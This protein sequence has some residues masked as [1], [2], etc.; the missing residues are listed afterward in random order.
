MKCLVKIAP[1][2][3]SLFV[4]INPAKAEDVFS[5]MMAGGFTELENWEVTLGG[6]VA[7]APKFEGSKEYKVSALPLIDINWKDTIFLNPGDGLGVNVFSYEGFTFG[8]AVGYDGGRKEKGSR[9]ELTGLGDVKG[10]AQGSI[11]A[12]YQYS[13][14]EADVKINK[15]FS[16]SKSTTVDAGVSAFIPLAAVMGLSM[17]ND[18]SMDDEDGPNGPVLTLGAST[19]WADKNHM[20][21]YFGV[22]SAQSAAS[23][24]SQFDAKAG[25]KS[26]TGS[27]G[28][29][30]PVTEHVMVGSNAEY[31]RL[32]GDAADSS[33]TRKKDQFSVGLFTMYKF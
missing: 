1:A 6:G 23:G 5:T 20:K 22:T 25:F 12:S 17:G 7:Y 3:L 33:I 10:G 16:G 31:T 24:L 28:L 9:K 15:T 11:F 26:V 32:I 19:T 27:V 2:A 18:V 21:S 30:V 14:L 29:L 4:V 13:F 8:G